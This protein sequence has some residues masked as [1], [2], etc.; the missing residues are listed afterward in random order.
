LDKALDGALLKISAA[1]PATSRDDAER[2]QQ[3]IHL[4]ATRWHHSQEAVPH[5]QTIQQA[6]WVD[7]RILLTYANSNSLEN[8]TNHSLLIDPYGLVAEASVWYLIGAIESKIQVFRV[9]R[10]QNVTITEEH[11]KRPPEF[12]LTVYWKEHCERLEASYQ[13]RKEHQKKQITNMFPQ[14]QTARLAE[15]DSKKPSFKTAQQQSNRHRKEDVQKNQKR[16]LVQ[17][18][19]PNQ[20][21]KSILFYFHFLSLL[22]SYRSLADNWREV[23][24]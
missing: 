21:K 23:Y 9:S 16:R 14:E 2:M 11:F 6:V 7:R 20:T 4:D 22:Y 19:R 17:L 5:L 10:I 8:H 13:Q 18:Q 1:L 15:Q 24:P 12:D 3:R